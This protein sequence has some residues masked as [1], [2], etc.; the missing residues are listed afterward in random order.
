MS[1]PTCCEDVSGDIGETT[2]GQ[3]VSEST[4]ARVAP[5][6]LAGQRVA[7][8]LG[9]SPTSEARGILGRNRQDH[10]RTGHAGAKRCKLP[11][12][13]RSNWPD[14]LLRGIS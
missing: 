9:A 7:W 2:S 1:A 6:K 11:G 14:N 13:L 5:A 10:I 8:P 12:C 3:G 4:V